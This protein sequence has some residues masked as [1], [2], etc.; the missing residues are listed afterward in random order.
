[1]RLLPVKIR[2]FPGWWPILLLV[3]C[4]GHAQQLV[5]PPALPRPTGTLDSVAVAPQA[6][7][8][9]GRLL[10]NQ[11]VQTELD[12][13]IHNLYNF[14]FDKADRQFRSLRRHHPQHPVAYFLL[15]LTYATTAYPP[16]RN[17]CFLLLIC[18][19]SCSLGLF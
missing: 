6:I 12:G 13:E 5:T 11:D 4:R 15:S 18:S 17:V 9:Q 14:K 3:I 7:D 2:L 1:M 16:T 10:L 19:V 8:T